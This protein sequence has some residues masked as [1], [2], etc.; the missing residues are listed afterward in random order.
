MRLTKPYTV[1]KRTLPSGK[2]VFYY[3]YRKQNGSLS[4]LISTG[5]EV[6]GSEE[7][8]RKKAE[9]YVL[10]LYKEGKIVP[11]EG[12]LFEDYTKDFFTEKCHYVK[13]KKMLGT[14]TSAGIS[15]STID[16]YRKSLTYQLLPFFSSKTIESITVSQIKSWMIKAS[17]SWSHKTINN[18]KSVLSIILSVAVEDGII[19]VNPVLGI[20]KLKT[21][22]IERVLLTLEEL[23][24]VFSEPW[25]KESIRIAAVTASVTGMRIGEILALEKNAVHSDYLDVHYSWSSKHG[26]GNTKTK[27]KRKVP[28]PK[29]LYDLLL[30]TAGTKYIFQ[31][32]TNEKP[33]HAKTVNEQF[34]S[35]L[36]KLGIEREKR[37]IDVHSFRRI[38][39]SYLE[40]KNVSE[41]KIRAV[42]GHKD[43]SM[44]DL[45]TYWTP[46]MFPEIYAAQEEMIRSILCQK[47]MQ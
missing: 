27:E 14:Q 24:S 4:G 2:T 37:R 8:A 46:D 3:R 47:Q 39:I 41:P 35:V 1:T 34:Y 19:D 43:S 30:S 45:Y 44:T 31:Q 32:A 5:I 6:E 26:I 22:K 40:S 28:I 17:D 33:M 7:R 42:V 9:L 20:E 38:F 23:Q 25:Q 12:T 18:A 15:P 11:L 13:W 16:S 21:D 29:Q 36:E 10:K